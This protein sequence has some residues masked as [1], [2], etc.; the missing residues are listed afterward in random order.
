MPGGAVDEVEVAVY[1][2]D[3]VALFVLGAEVPLLLSG[4]GAIALPTA[5]LPTLLARL[6]DAPD[7]VAPDL[8]APDSASEAPAPPAAS[9]PSA[10]SPSAA[11]PAGP[12]PTPSAPAASP[13]PVEGDPVTAPSPL[14]RSA[15]A[16][17]TPRPPADTL[18]PRPA[19][20]EAETSE[21]ALAGTDPLDRPDATLEAGDLAGAA[22]RTG[23]VQGGMPVHLASIA[24]HLPI[25]LY[26]TSPEG[27]VLY[28]NPALARLLDVGSVALLDAVDV[29]ADLGYPREAF[30]AEISQ[31]GSVRNLV[32]S[33]ERPSGERVH[34]RE[35]ARSIFDA[36]GRLVAYEGTMEDVTAEIER[37]TEERAVNRQHRAIAAFTASAAL[38]DDP[39]TIHCSAAGALLDAVGS[40]WACLIAGEAPCVTASVGDVPSDWAGAAECFPS[41][42]EAPV[43][44]PHTDRGTAPL[45]ER[46]AAAGV[47]AYGAVPVRKG[48]E[49]LG[50]LLWGYAEPH[51]VTDAD[52]RGAESLA[53]H[54]GSHLDRATTLQAFRDTQASLEAIAEYTPHVLYRLRYT[55]DGPVYEYL[56]PAVETLTGMTRAEV[57]ARGGPGSLVETRDVIEG[58]GMAQGPV[59]G[60]E[61]YR[62]VYRMA[63]AHGSRWVENS[64]RQWRDAA[65]H[66]VGLIGVLQDVTERKEREDQLADAAQAALIR[67]RALV[68]LAHLDGPDGFGGPA[69]AVVAA[70][71][72]ASDVSFWLCGPGEPCR[73]LHAPAPL[74]GMSLE[75]AFGPASAQVAQHRALAVADAAADGRVEALG[76]GPFVRAYGL[77]SLLIAPVRRRGLSAG[78]VAVHRTDGPHEWD[79][80][81]AEFTAAVADA[82]ALALERED[83][84]RVVAE[85]VGA[86]EAAEVGRAA[87]ER[88]NRL[89]SAFLANMSHE[90]RTPLTG[91][92]GFADL[93]AE[94]VPEAH[95]ESVHLIRRNGVRLLDTLNSVLD[96]S[97]LE[98]GEYE[99]DLRPIALASAVVAACEPLRVQA[100]AKGL[101]FDLDLD[102]EVA[103]LVDADALQ[104]TLTHVVGNAVKFT[105]AGGILVT[106]EGTPH[107]ALLR[108]ADTGLG[109]SQSALPEVLDAFRQENIGHSR[110]HEGSGLGLTVARRLVQLHEGRIE[111]ESEQPGGTVVTIGL[112]RVAVAD[113][114]ARVADLT[115]GD[116]LAMPEADLHVAARPAPPPDPGNLLGEPFDF[117][118]L[119][120]PAPLAASPF[121]PPPPSTTDMFDFRFG[122]SSAPKPTPEPAPR[123]TP[124]APPEPSRRPEAPSPR[125]APPPTAG[126][127]EP[128]MIIR[129]SAP[130]PPL[131]VPRPT[132]P[133]VAPP[134][135]AEV[136]DEGDGRP[137]VLVVEDND[138]TRMLLER[139]LRAT[140]DVTAVGDARSALLAMNQRR[141]AAL[142]LDIN[143]GGKETGAD[144]LRIAR[145]LPNYSGVFAVAL[146]AYALPGDRERLIESGFSAYI[147]KP[148]TRQSLM[149]TLEAGVS[150]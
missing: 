24:D 38:V 29:R 148:F 127:D 43:A 57:D 105:D 2:P 26:R 71:L 58:E 70:T 141:F 11:A 9:P 116:G 23:P 84:E 86:R 61:T 135:E 98:A 146:T 104:Q 128:V 22:A 37:C 79:A 147:S 102:P 41:L 42:R 67:Q 14:E 15:E 125:V 121:E 113:R 137:T 103:A 31:S 150:A 111:I 5:A 126:T 52:I 114:P 6:G 118:F 7:P 83:R 62:A 35:N 106:L 32:V 123:P 63:T 53:W 94:E 107:E 131:S 39:A 144:V 78:F 18:P 99:A 60:A 138:D 89:K 68:D 108:V 19:P 120:A 88:M 45:A 40:D 13:A 133:E 25:G 10:A 8:V 72:G 66:R 87:A 28:A 97:R 74:D 73:A 49:P 75:H 46:L 69:A 56:S 134:D 82:V 119:T 145:S 143:L 93:L 1:V 115:P 27:R 122:R 96:L 34:T 140:Y 90:I 21:P 101:R 81:E 47:G 85:L 95:R 36:D 30:A 76:L 59:E 100:L 132:I 149:E 64:A 65:G 130:A 142:V 136:V 3:A 51:E 110:S 92:L 17:G 139:I 117:T 109:I 20:A 55:P 48:G 91:I 50:V 16:D 77:R 112:P 129:N 12:A 54:V 44:V 4:T 124:A 33:W 80:G